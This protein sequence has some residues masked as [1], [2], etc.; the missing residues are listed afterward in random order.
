MSALS[1]IGRRTPVVHEAAVVLRQNPKLTKR[2]YDISGL[3]HCDWWRWCSTACNP[4]ITSWIKRSFKGFVILW[5]R[6]F[7]LEFH[8]IKA[9]PRLHWDITAHT[10]QQLVRLRHFLKQSA[11]ESCCFLGCLHKAHQSWT[12]LIWAQPSPFQLQVKRKSF[13]S[14]LQVS[15]NFP[16][17]DLWATLGW[18]DDKTLFFLKYFLQVVRSVYL[19]CSGSDKEA[20]LHS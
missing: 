15:H 20:F 4:L 11:A 14:Q 13:L 2:W 1:L 12:N 8:K 9:S 10:Q 7:L 3:S 17:W 18:S 19:F 5:S 6:V 16:L